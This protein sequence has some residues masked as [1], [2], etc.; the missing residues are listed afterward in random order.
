MYRRSPRRRL[1]YL[2]VGI[3]GAGLLA[4][5][6]A[7]PGLWRAAL[8]A[9]GVLAAAGFGLATE[10]VYLIGPE[11]LTIKRGGYLA[12]DKLVLW[13]SMRSLEVVSERAVRLELPDGSA[14]DVQLGALA[15]ADRTRL[16]ITLQER[17]HRR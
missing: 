4:L 10:P 3:I 5:G 7:L 6:A 9:G 2:V 12:I 8:L 17:I 13:P 1:I 15:P 16:V 14:I 11:G